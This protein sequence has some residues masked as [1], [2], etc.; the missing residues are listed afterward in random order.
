MRRGIRD[1]SKPSTISEMDVVALCLK[2]QLA[3]GGAC[4]G[5]FSIVQVF[6]LNTGRLVINMATIA[7]IFSN[8]NHVDICGLVFAFIVM[9]I[10]IHTTK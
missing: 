1:L 5:S 2:G 4:H 6:I 7:L 9:A 3:K 8:L 10:L